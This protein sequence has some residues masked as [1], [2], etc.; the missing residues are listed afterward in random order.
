VK[1]HF[2]G[3]RPGIQLK[4][5]DPGEKLNG[6]NFEEQGLR[7]AGSHVPVHG[8]RDAHTCRI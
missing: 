7:S 2:I 5:F 3:K 1:W 6:G 4:A 8:S